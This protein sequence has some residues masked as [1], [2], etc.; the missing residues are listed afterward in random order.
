[1]TVGRMGKYPSNHSAICMPKD[2][3]RQVSSTQAPGA[4][5]ATAQ[6]V[7]DGSASLM[8]FALAARDQYVESTATA[9]QAL[10]MGCLIRQEGT[11][12]RSGSTCVVI[13][14]PNGTVFIHA[15]DMIYSGRRLRPEI[16]GAILRAL[17]ADPAGPGAGAGDRGVL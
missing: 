14:T 8:D 16:H 6:Q 17:G 5:R 3:E 15:Q 7:E 11:P 10:H 2:T 12:W 1:M 13:L 4:P 9:N